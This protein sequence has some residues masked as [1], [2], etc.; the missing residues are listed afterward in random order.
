MRI[1]FGAG[2]ALQR[3]TL[4]VLILS[5]V[6][7]SG[8]KLASA[9]AD[10]TSVK[11]PW[12]ARPPSATQNT[13]GRVSVFPLPGTPVASPETEVSFRGLPADRIGS[14]T[15]VGSTTGRHR[16][17]LAPHL[18]GVGASFVPRKPFAAGERVTVTTRLRIRGA[19]A[20]RFAFTIARPVADTPFTAAT[21]TASTR[22]TTFHSR[23]DL[24]IGD[25]TITAKKGA[26]GD[27]FISVAPRRGAGQTGLEL[28]RDDGTRVWFQPLPG[29]LSAT[30]LRRQTFHG[31][32]VLTWWQGRIGPGHGTGAGIVVDDAYRRVA[33]FKAGNGYAADLHEFQLTAR[34]TAFVTAYAPVRW[35]LAPVGGSR[36]G[37][38]YDCIAQEVEP[39]TGRVLFEWHSLGAVPLSDTF[40]SP[41]SDP[42]V[43]FDYFHINSID[44]D[45]AG[46][47]LIS[48]RGTH[49]V[50]DV[51]GR[52]GA[53]LWRIG[54]KRSSFSLARG[55][56]FHSQHDA[57]WLSA[58][59]FSLFDNGAGV[60]KDNEPHSRGLV[61]KIDRRQR[62]VRL[63]KGFAQP[64]GKLFPSQGNIQ[65][66]AGG[67]YFVGW[68]QGP[69][70]TEFSGTGA[71]LF[72]M[73]FETGQSYRAYRFA[74]SGHPAA[75]PALAASRAGGT[76]TVW[77]SWNGATQVASWQALAGATPTTMSPVADAVTATRF[78]TRLDVQTTAPLVAVR[79]L[80][81]SGKT[82]GTSA[83]IT[84]A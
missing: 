1:P 70:A 6:G 58:N 31:R 35:N 4:A 65:R 67:R 14:V 34:G 41:P 22:V 15:V 9:P 83:P 7:A 76:T 45:A 21:P 20:G 51:D 48:G 2:S 60:G 66:L 53:V 62:R 69:Y 49:T 27:G 72:A 17:A 54:G 10:G 74:W 32:P 23:P 80:D 16:G 57:K 19:V 75:P 79:A 30:D 11:R 40:A 73:H 55:V 77:A 84:P 59:T 68:G 29:D 46:N 78:E 24:R 13:G 50:Y 39:G 5:A 81:R 63:L 82:L 18:D 64:D 12:A 26:T 71:V 44:S 25:V 37:L 42:T 61:L 52:T 43:R 3:I 8:L 28:L 56:P 36:N 33:T 47:V 38:A